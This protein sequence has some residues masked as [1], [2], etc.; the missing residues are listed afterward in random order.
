MRIAVRAGALLVFLT[1]LGCSSANSQA[2]RLVEDN[3]RLLDQYAEALESVGKFTDAGKTRELQE[4]ITKLQTAMGANSKALKA[5]P[6]IVVEEIQSRHKE[7]TDRIQQRIRNSNKIY[8][9]KMPDLKKKLSP[10]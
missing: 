10:N 1:I 6:M 7:E 4:R 9:D 8:R 3:L 2:E 5:Y